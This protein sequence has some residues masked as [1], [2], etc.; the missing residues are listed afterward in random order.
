[1]RQLLREPIV[2][3]LVAGGVL[4]ALYAFVRGPLLPRADDMS[5]IVDRRA[6]L[7]F[8]QYRANAFEPDTFAAALDAMSAEEV[9][10]LVKAYVDDEI[11]YREALA[12][13]LDESDYVIRQRMIQKV[14]F[15]LG[16]AADAVTE[17]DEGELTAYFAAH[18]AEYAI[19]PSITFTHVFFDSERRGAAT[20]A[21][22]VVAL[23][24]LNAAGAGFNDAGDRGDRFPFLKN[25]VERTL[26]H[27]ASHFG[28]EFAARIASLTPSPDRWQGPLRSAY[29][30]HLVLVTS[31]TEPRYPELAE[32]RA[33]V[34]RDYL[35]QRAAAERAALLER[36]R[37]RY[38]VDVHLEPTQ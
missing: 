14:D 4:F 36:L 17:V 33:E 22:A 13:R 2:H 18:K 7:T 24:E 25:Y 26:D 35:E 32:V 10:A 20:H 21:D 15:L 3:F 31:R 6:L 23:R 19:E 9:E 30:E 11:L 8:M 16:D 27:V 29:G 34:E 28:T 12:L 38:R 1:M 5:I 37:E